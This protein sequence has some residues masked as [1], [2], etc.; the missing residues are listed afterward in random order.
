VLGF[1]YAGGMVMTTQGRA[2]DYTNTRSHITIMW[3]AGPVALGISSALFFVLIRWAVGLTRVRLP[4]QQERT[5]L[6]DFDVF[7]CHN[8]ADKPAVRDVNAALR[9][10]GV[11]T[12]LDEEQLPLGLPWQ[13]ELEKHIGEVRCALVFVGSEGLGPWQHMEMR[14][15]LDQLMQRRCPVVPVILPSADKVEVPLFLKQLTWVDLRSN[16]ERNIRRL[17][18]EI[19]SAR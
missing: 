13:D 9:D 3:F 11:K 5:R 8:S 19:R 1:V 10:G 14:A 4:L 12:W 18:G 16:F 7:L 15:L 6:G 2:Y 17:I